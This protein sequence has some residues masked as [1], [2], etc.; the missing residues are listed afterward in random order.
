MKKFLSIAIA[1]IMVAGV[2]FLVGCDK[3][4]EDSNT[5]APANLKFGLGVVAAYGEVKD[6]SD[7]GNGEGEVVVN[8]ASVL[9]DSEGKIVKCVLDCADNKAQFTAEGTAVEA[10]EFKTKYEMGDD[11]NMVT[12]GGAKAEWYAQADA[13]A[14]LTVGKT[15]D[16]VK[17]LMAEDYKGTDEVVNAGC[18]IYVSDFVKA[19]EAAYNNAADSKATADSTLKLGVVTAQTNKDVTD[20][21]DGEI[22]LATTVVATALDAEGKVIVAATDVASAKLT[23]DAKGVSTTDTTAAIATK[24]GLGKD[25]NMAA[26]G[27]DLN[28]DGVVKEWFE[29]ADAFNAALVGKNATEIGALAVETGYGAAD[30]QTAGCTIHV[31]DMV[32]AAVKAATK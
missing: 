13:F 26:Y 11:Y 25:Y 18:T 1:I 15:L 8:V 32:K 17:A 24:K 4:P 10:G 31:G 30:L 6:A 3:G 22:E 23:F 20:E 5:D 2:L 12:Y 21:A 14:G 29:Q 7:E 27:N 19:I 16:E 28:G 9:V